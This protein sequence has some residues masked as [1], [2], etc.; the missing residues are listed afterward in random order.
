MTY[1]III[2]GMICS[3]CINAIKMAITTADKD[4]VIKEIKIGKVIVES[5]SIDK[6]KNSISLY[7]YK[8]ERIV[9]KL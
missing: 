8:I 3:G 7:G 5:S 6:I 9:E 1:E 2:S 4:S